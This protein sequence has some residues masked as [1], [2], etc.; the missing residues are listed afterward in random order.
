[1]G[2]TIKAGACAI[3]AALAI[4]APAVAQ[5]PPLPTP[6]PVPTVPPLPPLPGQGPDPQPYQ[7][8]DGRGFHDVLPS[9]TAGTLVPSPSAAGRARSIRFSSDMSF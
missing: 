6:P 1:M 5:I 4:A 3:V 2:N 8:N 9:G 7:A